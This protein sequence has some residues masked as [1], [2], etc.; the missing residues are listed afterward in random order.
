MSYQLIVGDYACS[1]WSPRGWLLFKRFGLVRNETLITF[2]DEP[3]A[4]Q[5]TDFFP[6]KTA[7]TLIAFEGVV[8]GESLAMAEKLATRHPDVCLWPTDPKARSIA[9]TRF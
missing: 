6:A 5:L 2:R 1:S 7:P 9:R 8:I 3:V 4:D